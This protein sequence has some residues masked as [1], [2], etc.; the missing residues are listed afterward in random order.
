MPQQPPPQPPPP[1]E[2]NRLT[3]LHP[4]HAPADQPATDNKESKERGGNG[5]RDRKRERDRSMKM[6]RKREKKWE[7]VGDSRKRDE[8][9]GTGPTTGEGEGGVV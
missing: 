1:P 8:R 4:C 5:E 2:L 9:D 3:F 6:E 7:R